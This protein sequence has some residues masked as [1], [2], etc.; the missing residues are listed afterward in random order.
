MQDHYTITIT[1]ERKSDLLGAKGEPVTF[2]T[3]DVITSTKD[4]TGAIVPGAGLRCYDGIT[5]TLTEAT[6]E[7]RRVISLDQKGN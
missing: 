4:D 5:A 3:Y 7:V 2:W 1:K 6:N